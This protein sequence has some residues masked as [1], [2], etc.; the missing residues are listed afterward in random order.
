MKC[1]CPKVEKIG[2][3]YRY[4]ISTESLDCEKERILISA[5]KALGTFPVHV[6]HDTAKQVGTT[7]VF[8]REGE[9]IADVEVTDEET[10]GRVDRGELPMASVGF[11]RLKSEKTLSG[12]L[13]TTSAELR[14]VSLV[15]EGCNYDAVREKRMADQGELMKRLESLANEMG[16]LGEIKSR[17]DSLAGDIESLKQKIL[18]APPP[19][20]APS[21]VQGDIPPVEK[22]RVRLTAAT[23]TSLSES[24]RSALSDAANKTVRR[25]IQYH[26]GR[27]D[28]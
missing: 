18:P 19:H 23:K 27:L 6:N 20:Q 17:L 11:T 13:I 14:E 24:V 3:R 5:W 8:I 22:V 9:L 10:R 2:S 1:S 25:S 15:P 16:T 7:N 4:K 21:H 26:T 28:D 12:E